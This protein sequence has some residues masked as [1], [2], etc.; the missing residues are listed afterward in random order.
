MHSHGVRKICLAALAA[1]AMLNLAM[2]A[3]AIHA[4]PALNTD[5]MA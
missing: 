1:C 5:F 2:A 4:H 3:W